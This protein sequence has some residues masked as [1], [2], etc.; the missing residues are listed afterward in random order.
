M[1]RVGYAEQF[2]PQHLI[3]VEDPFF[4]VRPPAPS[5][6][7]PGGGD[8]NSSKSTT[9]TESEWYL[10]L[11][12]LIEQV[13]DRLMCKPSTRRVVC[14]YQR[15]HCPH[16]FQAALDQHLWNRGVPA[17]ARLDTLQVVPVAQGWRRGLVVQ[18]SREET[19]CVCHADGYALPFTHQIVP[20]GYGDLLLPLVVEETTPRT[21]ATVL[22]SPEAASLRI[23]EALRNGRD[24]PHSPVAAIL[25]CLQECPIDLRSHVASNMVF[26][27]DGVALLPDL[28][29]AVV[30][31]VQQIL[32]G[33]AAKE[34]PGVGGDDEVDDDRQHGG[35]GAL[36]TKV[37]L[38]VAGL[39]PLAS[40]VALTSCAPHRPDW[41]AWVGASLWAATWNKYDDDETPIPWEANPSSGGGP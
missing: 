27:G 15:R 26:C 23:A 29:R 39:R 1:C 13:Y 14:L 25:A 7:N 40:K 8:A 4:D 31:A 18:V 12:P 9:K 16:A 37:P 5:T 38:N 35:A 34:A 22:P 19:A 17:L 2:Q 32:E 36:L 21:R 41:I 28:P 6:D 20:T 11:A 30:R 33:T 3:R 24:D 10:I